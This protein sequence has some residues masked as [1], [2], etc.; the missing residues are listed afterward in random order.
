MRSW[1]LLNSKVWTTS[2]L[3]PN[4][5]KNISIDHQQ[6]AEMPEKILP[7]WINKSAIDEHKGGHFYKYYFVHEN[8]D[9]S[10]NAGAIISEEIKENTDKWSLKD[11]KRALNALMNQYVK[12]WGDAL[13]EERVDFK[14]LLSSKSRQRFCCGVASNFPTLGQK[15]AELRSKKDKQQLEVNMI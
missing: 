14:S 5:I 9:Y 4:N 6:E 3:L 10:L 12:I 13:G 7:T 11:L 8:F 15:F 2:N 1:R